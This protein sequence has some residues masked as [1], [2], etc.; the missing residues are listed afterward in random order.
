MVPQTLEE[1]KWQIARKIWHFFGSMLMIA[2]FYLWRDIKQPIK[3]ADFLLIFSWF[4]LF[5]LGGVDLLRFYIPRYN[6][7]VKRL[8]FYGKIM[9]DY[10][11]RDF[12]AST[13]AILAAVILITIYWFG[14]CRESTLV[15]SILV[16]GIADP[17]AAFVRETSQEKNWQQERVLGLVTFLV[18]SFL[19][20]WLVSWLTKTR[21][22]WQC[23]LVTSAIVA[24]METYTKYLVVVVRPITRQVQNLIRH[25]TTLWLLHFWPD[26]NLFAPL[27]VAV[28]IG[29]LPNWI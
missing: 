25:R 26:D 5:L 10:E 27:A 29:V 15:M 9:R 4:E 23:L 20:M 17:I 22:T 28:L 8:F 11:E 2:I 21:L 16:F 1:K 18:A 24:L 14:W 3:G 6:Q 19:V 7:S 13:Y 12:N